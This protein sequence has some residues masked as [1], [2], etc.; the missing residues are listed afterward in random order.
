MNIAIENKHRFAS[1]T[2]W[3]MARLEPSAREGYQRVVFLNNSVLSV[4]PD[5]RYETRPEGTDAAYEQAKVSGN[6]LA[7]APNDNVY[8]IVWVAI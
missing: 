1:P 3:I 7:Y 4:Q 5:G 6:V 8:T 2:G